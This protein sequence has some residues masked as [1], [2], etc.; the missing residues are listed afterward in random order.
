M[1]LE[2]FI[3]LPQ[4]KIINIYVD[5]FGFID[6]LDFNKKKEDYV[7]FTSSLVREFRWYAKMY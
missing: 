4:Q 3:I 2:M 1:A 7:R 5:F 6:I